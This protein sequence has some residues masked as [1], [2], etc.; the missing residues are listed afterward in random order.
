MSLFTHVPHPHIAT[1]KANAPAKAADMLPRGSAAERF[2]AFLCQDHRQ[3]GH[4][5]VRI[6]LRIPCADLAAGDAEAVLH[7]ALQIQAHLA[8]QDALLTR[9]VNG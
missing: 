7:E 9:L 4:Y 3:R 8:A 6:S 1:S 5:V 2:N